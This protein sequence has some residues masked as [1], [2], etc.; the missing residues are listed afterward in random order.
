[1]RQFTY[2]KRR[3]NPLYRKWAILLCACWVT[4]SSLS[5]QTTPSSAPTPAEA[6]LYGV[7]QG[8]QNQIRFYWETRN[9][10]VWLSGYQIKYREP[11][12][13][14]WTP[15]HQGTV[16]PSFQPER[17]WKSQG[18]S[19][20]EV[21][22][23]LSV[24]TQTFGQRIPDRPT[25]EVIA[26]LRQF[27]G[28]QSGDRLS[29]KRDFNLALFSGFALVEKMAGPVSEYEQRVYGLFTVD[30]QGQADND[31]V[32]TWQA[33]VF[34]RT[35]PTLAEVQQSVKDGVVVLDWE[36]PSPLAQAR[37]LFG[38]WIYREDPVT[39][40]W[41]PLVKTPLG[42]AKRDPSTFQFRFYD[43]EGNA[44]LNQRYA[45]VGESMFQESF[46][47]TVID[48][49]ADRFLPMPR[50]FIAN[51]TVVNDADILLDWTYPDNA[52]DRLKGFYVER[53]TNG[54]FTRVSPLL[55]PHLRA[56]TD[57]GEKQYASV[58]DF[59]LVA[60]DKWDKEW[61]GRRLPLLYLGR[62]RPPK[63][64]GLTGEFLV[65]NGT[66]G[67]MLKWTPVPAT[68]LRT[69]TF[70]ISSDL[71]DPGNLLLQTQIQPIKG[72]RYFYPLPINGG[73]WI[74][75]AVVPFTEEGISG[76]PAKV[77]V[78]IP[79]IQLPS[80][81]RLNA[82]FDKNA[83]SLQ[84]KWSYSEH[85]PD[86]EGFQILMDGAP[87]EDLG[88][89]DPDRRSCVI[90]S[91]DFEK[92]STHRIS[93]VAVGG[94]EDP[95]PSMPLPILIQHERPQKD[96][97]VPT[98]LAVGLKVAKKGK[99]VAT[100]SW[101]IPENLE[102]EGLIGYA[103]MVDY[104]QE[105]NIR[106]LNSLPPLAGPKFEYPLPAIANRHQFTFRL[107][108]ISKNNKTGPFAEAILTLPEA[109]E[110]GVTQ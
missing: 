75:V 67:V 106:R 90:E 60:V 29:Q 44:L 4:V 49:E 101:D 32:S 68:D 54:V 59:R 72:N 71:T 100:L 94:V 108:A 11:G 2:S 47:Q 35:E 41:I 69:D 65:K 87:L 104:A 5:A 79:T 15:V 85:V 7:I 51:H 66:H 30:D 34:D 3:A 16:F 103:L 57:Q 96:V 78:Y 21:A 17:N 31:P 63:P 97:P 53:A 73:R 56:F 74:N 105:G 92:G 1:M 80:P 45:I 25:N 55:S 82:S 48:F 107:A 33:Q 39:K 93:I 88:Q 99:P 98:G 86:L 76:E 12:S 58:Y 6:T 13:D 23:L 38:F 83:Y 28:L 110:K 91:E 84:L 102:E 19:E 26:L 20:E 43:T 8:D 22:T 40:E 9:W 27:D 24:R 62:S 95:E 81:T 109:P 64:S 70:R 42:D 89:L 10:P 18:L 52:M 36:Y 46:G 61:I 77:S 37:A 14:S 50:P